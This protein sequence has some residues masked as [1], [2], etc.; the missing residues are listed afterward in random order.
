M[1]VGEQLVDILIMPVFD[2]QLGGGV[3]LESWLLIRIIAFPFVSIV[4]I[5]VI[6]PSF[7]AISGFITVDNGRGFE[8]YKKANAIAKQQSV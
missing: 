6:Y 8:R 3:P 2:Q 5:V 1:I 4:N 7:K